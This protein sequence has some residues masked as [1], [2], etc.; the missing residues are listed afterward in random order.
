MILIKMAIAAVIVVALWDPL[1]KPTFTKLRSWWQK[2]STTPA[3]ETA[4]VKRKWTKYVPW[5]T[6]LVVLVIALFSFQ[7]S[8]D[9]ILSGARNPEVTKP[10]TGTEIF[11]SVLVKS[12]EKFDVCDLEPNQRYTFVQ[13]TTE[14]RDSDPKK[15]NRIFPKRNK[16]DGE[17]TQ[18]SIDG[19]FSME[20]EKLP[21]KDANYSFGILINDLPPGRVVTT[22]SKGCLKAGFNSNL[23]QYYEPLG[24]F[25]MAF[26]FRKLRWLLFGS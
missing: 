3:S 9:L 24:P 5:K 17:I 19:K 6:A 14:F 16:R 8:R 2:P 20:A 22:D 10:F 7:G 12:F 18:S 15:D 11:R 23:L 4:P 26:F 1:L 25:G 21:Y 13:A